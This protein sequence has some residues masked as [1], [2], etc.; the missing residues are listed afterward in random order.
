LVDG[1]SILSNVTSFDNEATIKI[2]SADFLDISLVNGV[3]NID[4]NIS[5]IIEEI[6]PTS[7]VLVNSY[8]SFD[9]INDGD[10][11]THNAS[12]N[13]KIVFEA[14]D[15]VE[16]N[17]TGNKVVINSLQTALDINYSSNVFSNISDLEY[18]NDD[19]LLEEVSGVVKVSL[20]DTFKTSN[21]AVHIKTI[22]PDE[23]FGIDVNNNI[24]IEDTV[25]SGAL[26]YGNGK[27]PAILKY[28]GVTGDYD[29]NNDIG[30]LYDESLL[31]D[32]FI[33]TPSE[34][35]N[36]EISCIVGY[37]PIAIADFSI[38]P[39]LG[40]YQVLTESVVGLGVFKIVDDG[41]NTELTDGVDTLNAELICMLDT[42]K[43]KFMV[44]GIYTRPSNNGT[45]NKEFS[46]RLNGNV[47]LPLESGS[48]Y[49]LGIVR[50]FDG[51]AF[52]DKN[53]HI[54]KSGN[55]NFIDISNK[56]QRKIFLTDTDISIKKL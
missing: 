29:I 32:T 30:D 1:V 51:I 28:T 6:D 19:F 23:S 12:S 39:T 46:S 16:L 41:G 13:S 40:N 53:F 35:G 17:L 55:S 47:I 45:Y 27:S 54:M 50:S 38:I 22:Y 44:Q 21:K 2:Q 56:T 31:E 4:A 34:T 7:N 37:F 48:K 24:Y 18:D 36:Y 49:S 5:K 52:V 14:G 26:D 11:F 8:S 25:S 3:L 43:D 15:N 20:K 33:F 42:R 10:T 9:I